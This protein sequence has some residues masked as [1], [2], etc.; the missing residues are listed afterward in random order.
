M[1]QDSDA[2][3][4][5]AGT[6][7]LCAGLMGTAGCSSTQ[8][9]QQGTG[10]SGFADTSA[11]HGDAIAQAA[12]TQCGPTDST[13]SCCLKQ[14]PGE[15]ERCGALDPTRVPT[16]APKQTPRT[17]P[18]PLPPPT[19]AAPPDKR[20]REQQCREYYQQCIA[21][22][23]EYERRGQHGRTICKSCYDT[24][25]AEGYWPAKVNDFECLGGF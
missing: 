13:V 25:N 8:A 4:F 12:P 3:R 1:I 14:H 21:L 11:H 19:S 5:V 15:Y 7:L 9:A 18:P 23:G 6:L 24:C 22:G 20:K 16:R 17:D 10:G 2:R